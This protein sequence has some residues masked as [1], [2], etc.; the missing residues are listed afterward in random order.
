[1][2]SLGVSVAVALPRTSTRDAAAPQTRGI[3]LVVV[4]LEDA[5]RTVSVLDALSA[6]FVDYRTLCFV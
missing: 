3:V 6:M 4:L 5:L 1:M 2:I